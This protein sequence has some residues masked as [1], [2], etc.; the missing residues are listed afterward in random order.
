MIKPCNLLIL[1]I[2]LVAEISVVPVITA[3][4]LTVGLVAE[5]FVVAPA[6]VL[7]VVAAL[8]LADVVIFHVVVNRVLRLV[9]DVLKA[10][11]HIDIHVK[12]VD[13]SFDDVKYSF[14]NLDALP[15]LGVELLFVSFSDAKIRQ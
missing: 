12:L 1:A 10:V 11:A 14:H 7:V 4:E 15:G 9:E 8:A 6:D 13:C 2:A 5:A 3:Q